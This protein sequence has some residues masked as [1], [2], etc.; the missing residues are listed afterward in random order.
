MFLVLVYPDT[1]T[2]EKFNVNALKNLDSKWVLAGLGT[3][4][5]FGSFLVTVIAFAILGG[6][7]MNEDLA[8]GLS[9]LVWIAVVALGVFGVISFY[10][11]TKNRVEQVTVI[12][13]VVTQPAAQIPTVEAEPQ[14]F[15]DEP[16]PPA[17]PSAS[18]RSM[19]LEGDKKDDELR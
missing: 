6:L 10:N 14:P 9:F 5:V 1:T 13:E 12:R 8:L 11:S 7:G 15:L 16:A 19:L 3:L 17:A 4:A 18:Y 2:G